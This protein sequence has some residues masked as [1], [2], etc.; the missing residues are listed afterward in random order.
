MRLICD[1]R[2][3]PRR[4]QN[5]TNVRKTDSEALTAD[6][7]GFAKNHTTYL[8]PAMVGPMMVAMVVFPAV[9]NPVGGGCCCS[10]E[11]GTRI[12]CRVGTQLRK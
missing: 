11:C 2:I 7:T 12:G 9:K 10:I 5:R 8:A 1:K 6:L 4:P 3:F